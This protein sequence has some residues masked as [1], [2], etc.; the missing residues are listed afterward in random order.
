[1]AHGTLTE[2]CR[3]RNNYFQ[4]SWDQTNIKLIKYQLM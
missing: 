2:A 4:N 3:G 1:M